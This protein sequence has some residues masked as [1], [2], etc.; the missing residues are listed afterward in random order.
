MK[1]KTMM[2]TKTETLES[3]R[4]TIASMLAPILLLASLAVPVAHSAEPNDA[5]K[6]IE[7][8]TETLFALVD[9]QRDLFA[10]DADALKAAMHE[11]MLPHVDQIY[12]ARLVLGRHGRGVPAEDI[13]RFAMGMG[14]LLMGRYGQGVLGFESR[15]QVEIL[16]LAGDNDARRTRVRTRVRLDGGSRVPVDYVLRYHD[17]QW[18]VFDV[19]VEGISYVATFRN[20]IG[21]AI[22]RDGFDRVLA[23]IEAG[24]L[25]IEV[26]S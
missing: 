22:R 13:E 10:R 18:Q 9:E 12:S 14:D 7:D 23:R 1:T 20:Q 26:E 8:I 21:D 11:H 3:A 17:D 2:K 6:L 4:S 19:I 24:T 25:E 15:D 5:V 16:A